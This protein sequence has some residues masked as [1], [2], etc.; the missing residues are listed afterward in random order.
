MVAE[1]VQHLERQLF[2]QASPDLVMLQQLFVQGLVRARPKIRFLRM[3]AVR[4]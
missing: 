4:N 1:P 3:G 2:G